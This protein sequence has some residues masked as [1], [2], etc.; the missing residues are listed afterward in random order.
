MFKKSLISIHKP[1]PWTK[2]R[3]IFAR[4]F[5]HDVNDL[6]RDVSFL[7]PQQPGGEVSQT[8]F[9]TINSS[10]EPRK[11]QAQNEIATPTE[12]LIGEWFLYLDKLKKI[13]IDTRHKINNTPIVNNHWEMLG[14]QTYLYHIDRVT[15]KIKEQL[16]T[17]KYRYFEFKNKNLTS[18]FT[19]VP[20]LQ[21]KRTAQQCHITLIE[22]IEILTTHSIKQLSTSESLE[23]YIHAL[24]LDSAQ[25]INAVKTLNQFSYQQ[26]TMN[27]LSHLERALIE[28]LLEDTN[29]GMGLLPYS[30]QFS[31]GTFQSHENPL[32][33]KVLEIQDKAH[34]D[35]VLAM[36]EAYDMLRKCYVVVRKSV[37]AETL[38]NMDQDI[39]RLIQ[40]FEQ[41]T[42]SEESILLCLHSLYGRIESLRFS[43][44]RE[45][46]CSYNLYQKSKLARHEIRTA[47]LKCPIGVKFL[48]Q[49]AL[50]KLDYLK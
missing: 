19:D 13:L 36:I 39:E 9:V 2:V 28:H 4:L 33:L 32:K 37:I 40:L 25:L 18:I 49:I 26:E 22:L 15:T 45:S 43:T 24:E 42:L 31:L 11:S 44:N 34:Q 17:F 21:A 20:F 7:M 3:D 8:P 16:Y 29:R 35:L 48:K 1:S 23:T 5:K 38:V 47:C 6:H 50:R 14:L 46:R 12:A 10:I 30:E 41:E 27:Q